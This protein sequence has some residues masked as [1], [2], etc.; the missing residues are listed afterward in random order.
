MRID[1]QSGLFV[2][3]PFYATTHYDQRPNPDDLSLIVLHAI[4]LPP[5]QFGGDDVIAFFQGKL[6]CSL[7]PYYAQLKGVRVSAHLFIR[8][9]GEVVQLVPFHL[10]AWHAGVSRFANR[11]GCNDFSIGIELEGT[12]T[13]AYSDAQ[14]DALNAV[15]LALRQA[16]PTLTGAPIVGHSDIAPDRKTDPGVGFAWERIL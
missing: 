16:Y 9:S 1:I 5:G 4:S 12:D 11:T 7:E 2:N 14:Y 10:R 13:R 15:V 6:D 3:A 8:R